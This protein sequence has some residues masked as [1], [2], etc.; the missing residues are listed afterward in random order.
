M[1][2][3]LRT[4]LAWLD[5][6]LS[7]SEVREIGKQVS[8]SP[9]A[10]EL[11]ERIQRV[12]RQRRLTVPPRTGPEAVDANL[13]AAYL[14]NELD[15]DPVA[16]LEKKYLTSDVLLAEVAS[17]HQILSLIGQKAKVPT[18]ARHRMYHLVKGREAVR[19]HAP[20]A[21][22]QSEPEPVAMQVQPWLSVPPPTRP[23]L[24]RFGPVG[25]VVGL[26]LVLCWSAYS[27]LSPPAEIAPS[28]PLRVAANTPA[29]QKPAAV[30]A[31]KNAQ[32]AADAAAKPG[33]PGIA[34]AGEPKG[35]AAGPAPA[36][37]PAAPTSADLTVNAGQRPGDADA[38]KTGDKPTPEAPPGSV[39][40]ARKPAGLLLRF[41]PERRDWER[42]TAATPLREQDRLLSLDPFRATV[43]LGTADVDLVGE[44]EVWARGSRPTQAARL[45]LTQGRVVL[46]GTTPSLPFEVQHGGITVSITPPPGAVVGV[47]RVNR[48][49]QG[50]AAASAPVL[51]ILSTDG[52]VKLASG[53][54]SETLEGPGEVAVGPDGRFSAKTARAAP[55][56]VTET[57]PTPFDRTVG[58]QFLKFFRADRPIVS[59]L[60][61]ASEDE[62]KDVCRR[63]VAA[64]RAVGDID[65]IVPLLKKQGDP[66]AITARKAA[67]SELRA[68]L[69][70][71]PES[72]RTLR[73]QLQLDLGNESAATVEK[74]LVGYTAR[75]AADPATFAKLVKQ[76]AGTEPGDVGVRELAL[77]NLMQLTGRDDLDYNPEKP[78]GKGLK[79]WQDLLRD[80]ELRASAKKAG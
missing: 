77:D 73:T 53:S 1:R 21:S 58:E 65:Y 19:S 36:S 20:R 57:E 29:A 55:A 76:L 28:A 38:A 45:S 62:Q 41:I 11:V 35:E 80:N 40:M 46:H 39:G 59:S 42:L 7:P 16:E 52:P 3:T 25:V 37:A 47:E 9:F 13:V 12:T 72:A 27:T 5:D 30:D 31:G 14:D 51:M 64:L 43:E 4:L 33:A 2:L 74:L 22:R 70:Q 8:E 61:E 26:I 60:V 50:A 79:A 17:V 66:T 48:R 10:T 24:E 54:H 75:E 32:V 71:S 56:W 69:D 23:F 44:T 18:E 49:A 34:A 15:P 63:A 78:E 68:H 6:T 67:I